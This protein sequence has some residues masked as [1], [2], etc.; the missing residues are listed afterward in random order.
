MLI[1]GLTAPM[2]SF[3]EV[4]HEQRAEEGRPSSVQDVAEQCVPKRDV[5]EQCAGCVRVTGCEGK[6]GTPVLRG[7]LCAISGPWGCALM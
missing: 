1:H 7:C 4:I 3:D 6:E 5:A 2:N